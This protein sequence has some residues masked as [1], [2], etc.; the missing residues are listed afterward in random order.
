MIRILTKLN[1]NTRI[2]TLFYQGIWFTFVRLAHQSTQ[3]YKANNLLEAG[4]NHLNAALAF[5]NTIS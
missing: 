2:Y 4:Q 1:D 5:I 3:T